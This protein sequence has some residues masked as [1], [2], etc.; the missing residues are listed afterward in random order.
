[1]FTKTMSAVKTRSSSDDGLGFQYVTHIYKFCG[2]VYCKREE[3]LAL[4][5]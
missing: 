2:V 5:P 4:A 3:I 1:M